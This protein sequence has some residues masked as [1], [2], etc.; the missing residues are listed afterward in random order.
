MKIGIIQQPKTVDFDWVKSMGM[1]FVEFDCND[2]NSMMGYTP[3][4]AKGDPAVDAYALH[5]MAGQF[6]KEIERTGITIGAVGRWGS[7]A[8]GADG[9][10]NEEEFGHVKELLDM[11]GELDIPV[12]C[13]S[14]VS[15]PALSLYKN[16]GAV[17]D[18]FNRVV[19]YAAKKNTQVCVVNCGMGGNFVRRPEM[20]DIVLPEVPGLKIKYDPSH[21]FIH[22]NKDTHK[23]EVLAYADQIGY[24]HIKGVLQ[25]DNAPAMNS[26]MF[27]FM[28]FGGE[29]AELARKNMMSGFK[30]R[31]NPPAGLDIIDWKFFMSCLYKGGYDGMLSLEPYSRTWS[32][33]NYEKGI[34]FTIN[35]LRSLMP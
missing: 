27:D 16:L 32:G 18:Y 15:N 24:V 4:T 28:K 34:R 20:W 31:D 23:A 35:H 12:Y 13:V 17:I 11:T 33:D 5:A 1:E 19:E 25:G 2:A 26:G 6:A 29:V 21:S 22:G 7:G 8:Y 30:Y 14:A 10:I 9:K 3:E